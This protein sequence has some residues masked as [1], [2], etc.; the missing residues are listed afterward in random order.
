MLPSSK[1][2]DSQPRRGGRSANGMTYLT[3]EMLSTTAKAAKIIAVR[4][5]SE[6]KYGPRVILK[7]ALD[8]QTIFWGVNIKKNPN[9]TLLEEKF[10][11]DENEWVDKNIQ[12]FLAKDDFSGQYFARVQFP[13]N[14]Q[15]RPRS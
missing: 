10:G 13:A 3:N 1:G 7:L 11:L 5:D 8:G 2:G 4:A 9:Y 15:R 6:N 12:L 14:E